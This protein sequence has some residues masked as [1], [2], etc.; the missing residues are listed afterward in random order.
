MSVAPYGHG[1]SILTHCVDWQPVLNV[2][3]VGRLRPYAFLTTLLNVVGR[4]PG[5]VVDWM[6]AKAGIK[7][8]YAV[9]LRDTG[10]VGYAYI[11]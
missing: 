5:N 9:H 7:Y 6:Y 8:S 2:V 4:A 3:Q 1:A 10:T 11:V